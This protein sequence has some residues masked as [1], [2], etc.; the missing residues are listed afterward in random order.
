[1]NFSNQSLNTRAE[2][3][4]V[5]RDLFQPLKSRFSVGRARVKLGESGASFPM[6]LAGLEGFSRP[7]W[8]LVPLVAGG[9]K[10]EGW[11]F[12]REGL[13]NGTNLDHPEF[14]GHDSG[15]ASQ[16]HVE[17]AAI[18]LVLAMVPEEIWTPLSAEARRNLASWLGQIYKANLGLSNFSGDGASRPVPGG[19]A[20]GCSAGGGS[21]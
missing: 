11:D 5:V 2:L 12:Y 4:Q 6:A 7:L 21:A 20:A 14:W 17:M 13:T 19:S 9:G 3:Q 16:M 18:G 1:M 10:F 8:G 15:R